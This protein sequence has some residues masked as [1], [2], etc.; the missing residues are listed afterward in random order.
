MAGVFG[1]LGEYFEIDPVI[2]RL[3]FIVVLVVTAFIPAILVY[4][5][6]LFV[7]PLAPTAHADHEARSEATYDTNKVAHE[8][9]SSTSTSA[10]SSDDSP[11]DQPSH[12]EATKTREELKNAEDTA[13]SDSAS[14]APAQRPVPPAR[15]DDPLW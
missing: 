14:D 9:N 10:D 11:S 4:I 5:L 13:T 12:P 15:R 6:A 8:A 3:A 7:I 2:L 1:G